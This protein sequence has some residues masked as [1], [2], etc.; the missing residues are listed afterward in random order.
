[1]S[2]ILRS[3]KLLRYFAG[4]PRNAILNKSP[5]GEPGFLLKSV[6]LLSVSSNIK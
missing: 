2:S 1:M 6:K 5:I 4:I 3:G